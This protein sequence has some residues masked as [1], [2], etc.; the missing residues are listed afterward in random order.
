MEMALGLTMTSIE[1]QIALIRSVKYIIDAGIPGDFVECGVWRGGNA[2]IICKILEHHNESGRRVWLYDTYEGMTEPTEIDKD[3]K[4]EKASDLLEL[5]KGNQDSVITAY[6]SL[7]QVKENIKN[8]DI[9]HK[10]IEFVQ[11]DILKTIPGKMPQQISL[12]RLDTDWYD[13]TYHELVH[14]FPRLV[15]NGILII[16]DYGHWRGARE[17]TDKY[18]QQFHHPVFMNRIDMTGRLIV[19]TF[20]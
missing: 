10:K 17:A 20:E 6:C 2:I 12:L 19:K 9:E 4:G 11:G 1:R 7:E 13:S 5:H 3:F 15:R 14:L 18:F 8:A 16:D